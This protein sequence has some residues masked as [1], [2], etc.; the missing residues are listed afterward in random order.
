MAITLKQKAQPSQQA[1]TLNSID[2]TQLK[3]LNSTS[4]SELFGVCQ[5]TFVKKISKREG[6][7][8]AIKI[9]GSK[10]QWR[11]CDL[12]AFQEKYKETA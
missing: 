5:Q 11:L 10:Q 1:E 3:L 8:A 7:P 2:P 12:L 6:F 9:P 4:A